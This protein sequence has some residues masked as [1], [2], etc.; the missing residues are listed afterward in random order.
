MRS[1]RLGKTQRKAESITKMAFSLCGRFGRMELEKIRTAI[2]A[3]LA[4]NPG[5]VYSAALGLKLQT[6]LSQP[7]RTLGI[8]KLRDFVQ[9]H[10]AD[11]VT[12]RQKDNVVTFAL[13][14]KSN[15]TSSTGH[16]GLS[17]LPTVSPAPPE[18]VD[19]FRVWKSP[20]RS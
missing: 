9:T 2:L 20:E 13:K 17:S 18:S 8:G 4:E 6:A 1:Q 11:Q 7:L 15:E 12:I 3:I 19:L 16:E 5:E 14:S 10:L